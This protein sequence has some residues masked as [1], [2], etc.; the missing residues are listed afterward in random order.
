MLAKKSG[1]S[2]AV[3]EALIDALA[4]PADDRFQVRR[5]HDESELVA[6]PH[7][8]G[9]DRRSLV[10][11]QV[12]LLRSLVALSWKRL[13]KQVG[14]TDDLPRA[15]ARATRRPR[16]RGA[17]YLRLW[18]TYRIKVACGTFPGSCSNATETRDSS[19]RSRSQ[20]TW[21]TNGTHSKTPVNGLDGRL[22]VEPEVATVADGG[23]PV[24]ALL[25]R[26][27]GR[28]HILSV[29]LDP[30]PGSCFSKSCKRP[31][32]RLQRCRADS[33]TNAG[34]LTV[35]PKARC[36]HCATSAVR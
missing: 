28:S 7:Y 14:F 8:G 12:T 32:G 16:C 11:I 34:R 2:D 36:S 4:I 23:D 20:T 31:A 18:L 13:S 26:R 22:L 15:D 3:H 27:T 35:P 21:T 25:W 19:P 24:V 17:F 9:I 6:D 30:W 5:P 29:H 10:S 33:R 1:I